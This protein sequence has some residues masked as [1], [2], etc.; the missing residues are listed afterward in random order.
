MSA[1]SLPLLTPRNTT[2]V[3]VNTDRHD[4]QARLLNSPQLSA[5]QL[6]N[7]LLHV[8]DQHAPAT[9]HKI[10]TQPPLLR[11]ASMGPRFLDAKQEWWRSER[12][13]LK[14]GLQIHKQ[15]FHAISKLI[16]SIIHQAEI[17]FYSTKILTSTSS[18]QLFSITVYMVQQNPHL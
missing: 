10:S 18:K 7:L 8:L 2:A 15:I 9:Q 6:H 4:L 14:S 11:F 13:W 3:D 17:L 16:N 1:A 12:Q 5:S